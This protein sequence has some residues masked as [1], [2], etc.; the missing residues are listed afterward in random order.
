MQGMEKP[1]KIG[2]RIELD[3]VG[4]GKNGD[5]LGRK[6]GFVIFVP[7]AEKGR[8]YVVKVTSVGLS[9]GKAEITQEA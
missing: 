6:D 7:S 3:I 8:K 1:V 2:D 9:C 4:T 5:G